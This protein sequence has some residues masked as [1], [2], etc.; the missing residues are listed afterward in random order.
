MWK[1]FMALIRGR[2]YEASEAVV[3]ANA[4]TILRQQIRDCANAVGAARKAVAVAVAQNE[5]EIVQ[6]TRLTTQISDLE[7]RVIAAIEQGKEELAREA[8]EVIALLEAERDSSIQAQNTFNAEITRLK[9]IV[10]Q[11]ES[12]LRELERGQRIASATDKT[13]RLRS[14]HPSSGISALQDAEKTLSRLRQRQAEIDATSAAMDEMALSNDPLSIAEKLAQAGCGAPV[15]TS[16][17]D[18]I[19]RL[20]AKM[21]PAT[22]TKDAA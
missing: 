19:A 3:D 7:N 9:N 18:V 12:R 10:S 16:A 15:K 13:Q 5:Q 8:A 14:T 6:H 4:M 1:S 17:D 22:T 11:S 21:T 2:S 20:T